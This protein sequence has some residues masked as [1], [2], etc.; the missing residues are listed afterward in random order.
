MFNQLQSCPDSFCD[1]GAW[2]SVL[3]SQQ[4]FVR[5]ESGL[6][7]T[8]IRHER[9]S[10]CMG[11]P[12][13]ISIT[14][15]QKRRGESDAETR[16][17]QER[18]TWICFLLSPCL[19]PHLAPI[20]DSQPPH[21]SGLIQG[22]SRRDDRFSA[23]LGRRERTIRDTNARSP[24][25]LCSSPTTERECVC[26]DTRGRLWQRVCVCFRVDNLPVLQNSAPVSHRLTVRRA[27]RV[28]CTSLLLWWLESAQRRW[29]FPQPLT[30]TNTPP[31]QPRQPVYSHHY[32]LNSV[33]KN[34]SSN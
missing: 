21:R 26:V 34:R 22:S 28:V 25:R 9:R 32:L 31:S 18:Q 3:I 19:V 17:V 24:S 12:Q 30:H 33:K 27:G 2:E 15:R 13:S 11:C 14:S 7:F 5:A 29:G 16:T 6:I 23:W 10:A 8:L 4:P 20:C 1:C